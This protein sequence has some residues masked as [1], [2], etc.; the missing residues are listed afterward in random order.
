MSG[1]APP[2]PPSWL[3]GVELGGGV[4]VVHGPER[5]A[6]E[7]AEEAAGVERHGVAEHEV[8]ELVLEAR[9]GELHRDPRAAGDGGGGG[10]EVV[11]GDVDGGEVVRCVVLGGL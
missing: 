2:P 5:E 9:H 7:G 6:A 4:E 11:D 10:G 8:A 3:C 1:P